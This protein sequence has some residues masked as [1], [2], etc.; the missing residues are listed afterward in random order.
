MTRH[1][2]T[3]RVESSPTNPVA[4]VAML[5]REPLPD[6][7]PPDNAEEIDSPRAVYRLVRNNPATDDDFRS[8]RAERPGRIFRNV[9]ECQARGLSVRTN[10]DSARELMELRAMRGRMLCE[11]QLA[12]GAGR[13]MQTGED[14]AHS[15]WWPMADFDILSN[16]Y[17][18][19][20]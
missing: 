14:P 4:T 5:Y 7:C 8:Q 1:A 16:C 10:L 20:P 9:T 13:I 6:D 19:T 17:V 11:V 3:A 18:V 12:R 15:T 2:L